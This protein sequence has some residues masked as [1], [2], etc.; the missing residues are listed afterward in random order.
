MS[1]EVDRTKHQA[2]QENNIEPVSNTSLLKI[3][4]MF[5]DIFGGLMC[6]AYAM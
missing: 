1:A 4:C 2:K 3:E 5:A 6:N